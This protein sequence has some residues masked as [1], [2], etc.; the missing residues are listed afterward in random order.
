MAGAMS[1]RSKDLKKTGDFSSSSIQ[2]PDGL[3]GLPVRLLDPDDPA[4]ISCLDG[5]MRRTSDCTH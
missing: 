2:V 1:I 5:K 3:P 4:G